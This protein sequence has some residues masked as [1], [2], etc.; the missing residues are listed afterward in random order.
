MRL[1]LGLV[2]AQTFVAGLLNVLVVVIALEMLERGEGWVGLLNGAIG[3]GG[4]IG[5]AVSA[6]VVMRRGIAS[7][8]GAGTVLFGAPLLLIAAW[9]EP[10]MAVVAMALI[11]VGNT[12]AD[13]SS[14]TLLQ[15][16]VDDAVLARVFAVL[17]SLAIGTIA[18]GGLLAPVAVDVLGERGALI[19]AGALLPVVVLLHAR[20]AARARRGRRARRSRSSTCCARCR[21]SPRCRSR[22]WSG[23]R[24][25]PRSSS[26]RRGRSSRRAT[27][28]TAST[29]SPRAPWP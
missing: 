14:S 19:V 11:G 17:E 12:L 29:S 5:V 3:I 26:A 28:A 23:S 22:C 2:A 4:L 9:E 21:S 20:A 15:R 10:L 6:G 13:V 24:S 7:V 18:V 16:A 1:I 25:T 8:F 27:R